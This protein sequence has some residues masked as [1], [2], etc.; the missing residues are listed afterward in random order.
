[1][2]TKPTKIVKG[3]FRATLALVISIVA[4]ILS[5]LAYN[6][7]VREEGFKAQVK[8]LQNAMENIKAESAEQFEKLRNETAKTL[9]KVSDVVREKK[10]AGEE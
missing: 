4:L 6:S 5:I 7:T 10:M 8:D 9:E 3:G 2:A 1:M